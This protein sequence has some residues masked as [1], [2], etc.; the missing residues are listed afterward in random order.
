[1]TPR[2]DGDTP[3]TYIQLAADALLAGRTREQAIAGLISRI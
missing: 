3:P 2:A 1:M